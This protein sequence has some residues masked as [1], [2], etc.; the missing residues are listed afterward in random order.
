MPYNNFWDRT[1][2]ELWLAF[3]KFLELLI[4]FTLHLVCF[5]IFTGF[6]LGVYWPDPTI[7]FF[8]AVA[9]KKIVPILE[10]N[11]VIGLQI[12]QIKKIQVLCIYRIEGLE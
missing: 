5:S 11:R 1:I 12:S 4:E 2:T 6:C 8:L 9:Q 3:V 10:N 7:S